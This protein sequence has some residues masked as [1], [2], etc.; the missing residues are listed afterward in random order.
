MNEIEN[1]LKIIPREEDL[2][3]YKNI[4][5][6][7]FNLKQWDLSL[8]FFKFYN[9]Y[10]H[11]DTL[12][13][14]YATI[15]DNKN[16]KKEAIKYYEKSIKYYP[17][18]YK[19]YGNLARLYADI[20]VFGEKEKQIYYTE[21]AYELNPTDDI[22]KLNMLLI[23]C[24]YNDLDKAKYFFNEIKTDNPSVLFSYGCFLI[25]NKEFK[26][27]FKLY[28]YRIEHDQQALPGG[29]K[30]IWQPNIDISDKVILVSYE[31]G[32]GDTLMFIRFVKD[33]KPLCK[34][35]KVLVQDE[36]YDLLKSLDLEIY[37][38]KTKEQIEYDYFVPMMDLPLLLDIDF[39]NLPEKDGYIPMPEGSNPLIKG[40]KFKIGI[41][42][43]GSKDGLKTCRDIP[44]K[45]LY[46][47]FDLPV[48]IYSFQKEDLKNQL[49]KVPSKYNIIK[50]GDT[51]KSWKDTAIAMSK[52]DLMITTDNGIL[53]LAGALGI[54]TFALFN[55][56]PE[57]RWFD[58][59]DDL[60]WYSIKPFQCKEFNDWGEV[61]KRLK[62]EVENVLN[63]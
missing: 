29:L 41:C 45:E 9:N 43:S 30:N 13:I 50:L 24:K 20:Y 59:N 23:A 44:L 6:S 34:Q 22:N 40:N 14:Y 16:N 31:Q 61:V 39:N 63:K 54:K 8:R 56:Y 4:A 2:E 15:F 5:I 62:K 26:D 49:D 27:G 7:L 52:M 11:D 51:F 1:L 12:C 48:E 36:L 35:V 3:N 60:K 18:Y 33:L 21:K 17:D 19:I 53:N 25:H 38:D 37:T 58:L 42:Y 10:K 46:P 47:I 57:F 28:R 32:F 55:K